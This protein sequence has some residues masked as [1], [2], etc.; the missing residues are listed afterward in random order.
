ML[1]DSRIKR[2]QVKEYSRGKDKTGVNLRINLAQQDQLTGWVY[3]MSE[4]VFNEYAQKYKEINEL[5]TMPT[6]IDNTT[7]DKYTGVIDNNFNKLSGVI[8]DLYNKYDAQKSELI[9]ANKNLATADAKNK[10]LTKDL[11]TKTSELET[12]QETYN[13]QSET[14][15]KVKELS[16]WSFI[17][18]KHKKIIK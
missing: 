14:L 5:T 18:G 13:T 3:I 12:L 9:T 4:E 11:E 6:V 16:L 2:K 8:T 15:D 7:L 1:K 10:I 17:M